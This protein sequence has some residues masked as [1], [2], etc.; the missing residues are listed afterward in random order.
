MEQIGVRE[1]KAKAS[2]I[3][4]DVKE[5]S[6]SYEITQRGRVIARLV[7]ASEAM[8]PEEWLAEVDALAEEIAK[9][10]TDPRSSVDLV[11]DGRERW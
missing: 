5:R 3:L 4:C 8:T 10:D 6:A 2:Q 11:N 9:Y 7:P 1:L